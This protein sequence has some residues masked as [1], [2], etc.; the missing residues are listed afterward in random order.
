MYGLPQA[1]I[2]AQGLLETRLKTAGYTQSKVTPGYW[3]HEWQPIS[4]TLFVDN[5]GVKY[6]G[7]NMWHI[8][9]MFSRSTTKSKKTGKAGDT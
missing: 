8:S 2:I 9:S 3:K 5:F 4:I 6:I 1:G 7:K